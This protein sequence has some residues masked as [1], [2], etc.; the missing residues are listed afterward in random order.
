[1]PGLKLFLLGP[2]RI[3]LNNTPIDIQRRKALA[4]LV[5][6]AVNGQPHS[7]DALST[8]FYPDHS[9]SRARAYLRRD[10]AVLNTSLAGE[11][12]I[13]D[14]DTVEINAEDD[15]W[16]D[17]THFRQLLAACQAHNHPLD[18][19][20]AE[21]ISLLTQAIA[22][23]ND[24]FLAG[25]TLRDCPEFDDW[26]FFQAEGLRQQLASTLERLVYGCNAQNEHEAA[27]AYARR[28]LTLD[29]LHEPAQRALIQAYDQ[30]GQP[31]AALRQYEEYVAL[32]EEELGLPPE[33]E[34][35]TLYE[36]I[37]AKRLF[38]PFIKAESRPDR[39]EGKLA[40]PPPAQQPGQASGR[41]EQIEAEPDH[42]P[43]A[44]QPPNS[45]K[46]ATG[47]AAPLERL[48]VPPAPL[49]GREVEY[50]QLLDALAQ[51][52]NGRGQVVFIEGEPGI[53][54]SRLAQEVARHA[55]LQ[56][57][58]VIWHKCYP[59]EQAM[60]YQALVDLSAKML[61]AWPASTFSQIP[62]PL[63]AE[64]AQ[65]APEI[66]MTFPNLPPLPN[67][68]AEA[69]Q[70]R[71]FRALH[72]FVVA[73]AQKGALILVIDDIHWADHVTLQFLHHLTHQIA[74]HPVLLICT[75]RTEDVALDVE[76]ATS[77]AAM[78]REA[79][80]T[81][82]RLARLTPQD[83]NSLIE[84]LSIPAYAAELGHWLYRETE[85]NPF[86]LMTILQSLQ[87]QGVLPT[88]P[89][90]NWSLN[91]QSLQA[92]STQLTLPDALRQSVRDRLR[93]VPPP[94]QQLLDITAVYG[95]RFD[96]SALQAITGE[97]AVTLLNMVEELT[98]RRLL[99]EEEEGR[100]Y[101][102]NHDKIRE[103]VY[104]D[105]SRMRRVLLHRQLAQ[106]LEPL[107]SHEVGRLAEH[108]EK[109]EVWDK[110]V[111]Y[112][113]QAGERAR[114]FFAME[115]A[116]DFYNRAIALAEAQ[117]AAASRS[118]LLNL[119]EQRG[120]TRGLVGGYAEEA[121]ADL[122]L[123]LNAVREAGDQN[124]ERVLLTRMGQVY[125][126]SDRYSE[127]LD[128]LKAAL[129]VARR[130]DEHYV[131][132]ALYHLGTTVWSQGY[133]DQALVY[134][135][136]AVDICQRL[137]LS[138]LVAVQAL[139][140]LG[141]AFFLAGRA[142]EAIELYEKSL[143]LARQIQDKGYESENLG[144]IGMALQLYGVANYNRAKEVFTKAL[145]I[146]RSANLEWHLV[147]ILGPLGLACGLSGNYQ[148]ALDYLT[149][150]LPIAESIGAKRFH[151]L[152]LDMYGVIWQ[153]LR[154]LN[155]AR[156]AHEQAVELAQEAGA[157][158]WLP[159]IQANLAID[160]LRL[161]DFSIEQILYTT[162]EDAVSRRLELH[163]VRC[164][165][166][167]A[168]LALAKNDPRQALQ[169]ADWLQ[170]LAQPGGLREM[171]AQAHRWRGEALLALEDFN[172]SAAELQQALA[173]AESIGRP[174]LQA[175][176]HAALARL[177]KARQN[178]EAAAQH[179]AQAGQIED[180]LME[181]LQQATAAPE[182]PSAGDKTAEY[183]AGE[184]DR[185]SEIEALV[186]I[187]LGDSAPEKKPASRLVSIGPRFIQEDLIAT[188]G[189]GEVYRG[190]DTETGQ[191]VAIKRLRAD[192]LAHNPEAVRRLI[193][194]GEI[195]RQLNHPNI[196]KMLATLENAGQPIIVM[197]YVPGGSLQKLLD[198]QPQLPLERVVDIGLE[199]ADALVRVHHV[200]ILHRDLKPANVLLA[201]DG[202][203]RLTD[204]GVAYLG[205]QT[206]RITQEGAILG[207]SV[208]MSPEAWRGEKLDARSDIW[209]FGILLYEMLAGQPP[210]AAENPV[211]IMTAILNEPV[212]TL[213][214]FRPDTPP[215]LAELVKQML[216]KARELR[217]DSMR[218]VAAGLEI[219]QR[220]IA[221][222][223]GPKD[224][225]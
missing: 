150:S 86:F 112:L 25:F 88:E 116:L 168:E 91:L 22:L 181:M 41:P 207:T 119:Y 75:F 37:K 155:K 70:A 26:Q 20:C 76:L 122:K 160:R 115:E 96:F 54:K 72:Q 23:Y 220:S 93:R 45:A 103:V 163:A 127:A 107:Y 194:E 17:V 24:D 219:I 65:L 173:L 171:V 110:A 67:G 85:G 188:G 114:Q 69:R 11:W 100:I 175:D 109:G 104:H 148:Q 6:L 224:L 176:V 213:S 192:L 174:R 9:Q 60:P 203:P 128:H 29:P 33:E 190:R 53:G 223:H 82:L 105:L 97:N 35:T 182:P 169:H 153:E 31:A 149:K 50:Q 159:R 157:G 133:N 13:T 196:V 51:T 59:S 206:S 209:S 111:A 102:F 186:A 134:H 3:E 15:L 199:L 78:Q 40:A 39:S 62:P 98:A 187:I 172:Q 162:L 5:Y 108:F 126:Y 27:I 117:P 208:Y 151:S 87:E 12:I 158:W 129:E 197:E 205:W 204:F 167:L 142:E 120:E 21:C 92:A 216:A 225:I 135:Q 178:E 170:R 164:L 118:M 215:A 166:G 140:G 113:A 143:R 8:L 46:D 55:Q 90:A 52:R 79:H 125:R 138:D 137:K 146:S 185:V 14:R 179:R 154:Q 212:P 89:D 217:I 63:L 58:G 131:A 83:A 210:F 161:G 7:R 121:I 10:L 202:T 165:E 144:N 81:H 66:L 1:M 106:A 47:E 61:D 193:R 211:A 73:P 16:I 28:W 43:P 57:V 124:R 95:R 56:G 4:L 84:S 34:T 36:A 101:D 38:G 189:M 218:Q 19:P 74:A 222:D 30:S 141:E 42:S 130:G 184:S 32:L 123:V 180:S 139:H 71:L 80:V 198:M 136:E 147:Q 2:P 214:Q 183:Y 195:L 201:D 68:L 177:F 44:G 48:P 200:G 152:L 191:P 77:V 18:K 99:R 221:A 64:L 132:D 94:A 156:A 49:V 145:Q